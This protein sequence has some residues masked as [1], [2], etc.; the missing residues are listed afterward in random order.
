MPATHPRKTNS[1]TENTQRILRSRSG[2]HGIANS[3][4]MTAVGQTQGNAL[5]ANRSMD[6]VLSTKTLMK[7][8][9][10]NVRTLN[11]PPGKVEQLIKEMEDYSVNIIGLCE[12]RWKE[13]GEIQRKSKTIIWSGGKTHHRGVG[14]VMSREA[15][16]AMITWEPINDRILTARFQS[17]HLKMTVVQAYAPTETS[18]DQEKDKFYDELDS[19]MDG[20]PS[21]DLVIVSGDFNAQLGPDRDGWES[22]IGPHLSG[23]LNDNGTRFLEFCGRNGLCITNTYFKHK[24]I[25]KKTWISPNGM[26]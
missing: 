11:Q 6:H 24:Q 20:I 17:K 1:A 2:D 19:T 16:K 26:T 22:T 21:H 3:H 7:F 18:S 13:N 23:T 14:L 5:G 8:A 25:H 15:R 12:M 9:T 10:W 4:R